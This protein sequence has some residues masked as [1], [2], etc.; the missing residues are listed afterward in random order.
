MKMKNSSAMILGG[1]LV[2]VGIISMYLMNLSYT[3]DT[4]TQNIFNFID[5]TEIKQ[6]VPFN[7]SYLDPEYNIL[8]GFT[9][10]SICLNNQT[11]FGLT[12]NMPNAICSLFWKPVTTSTW[13]FGTNFALNGFGTFTRTENINTIG[14]WNYIVACMLNGR[15]DISNIATLTVNNCTI[16]DSSNNDSDNDGIPD[17]EESSYTCGVTSYCSAGT[18]PV[19]YTCEEVSSTEAT[20]CACINNAGEV[21]PN[22]KPDGDGYNPVVE[23]STY[24][25]EEIY[26]HNLYCNQL[27]VAPWDGGVS[28]HTYVEENLPC[29]AYMTNICGHVP[30]NC[31]LQ[32]QATDWGCCLWTC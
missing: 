7:T 20:W 15:Y 19:D 31:E 21:H 2:L 11:T 6:Q 26:Q 12:S 28:T 3:P 16:P 9:P 4:N 29:C 25:T 5:N 14:S 17:D 24:T 32:W 22:W 10:S 23:E 8:I 1:M 30:T 18:C 27:G 13:K